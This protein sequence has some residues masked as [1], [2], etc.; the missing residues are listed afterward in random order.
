M[1]VY[2]YAGNEEL[3]T[4]FREDSRAPIVG[5]VTKNGTFGCIISLDNRGYIPV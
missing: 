1:N 2:T 3:L 4:C 5:V